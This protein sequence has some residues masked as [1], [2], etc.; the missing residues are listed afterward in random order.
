M[1]KEISADLKSKID[2]LIKQ[3]NSNLTISQFEQENNIP[4]NSF[5]V[6]KNEILRMEPTEKNLIIIIINQSIYAYTVLQ[7]LTNFQA[8]KL[9]TRS[10]SVI[11]THKKFYEN[12]PYVYP[13]IRDNKIDLPTYQ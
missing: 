9:F 1:P 8:A 13:Y 10:A 3:K 6:M 12:L 7:G 5:N 2:L 4:N 11:G